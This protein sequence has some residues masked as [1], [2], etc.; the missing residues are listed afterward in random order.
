V[1]THIQRKCHLLTE[2]QVTV[3]S[4]R[5]FLGAQIVLDVFL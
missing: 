1:G 2:G 4:G 3:R 5:T